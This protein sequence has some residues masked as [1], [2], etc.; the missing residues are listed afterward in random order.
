MLQ[1]ICCAT[2]SET[3]ERVCR[4]ARSLSVFKNGLDPVRCRTMGFFVD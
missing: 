4:R 1:A 2:V 3:S